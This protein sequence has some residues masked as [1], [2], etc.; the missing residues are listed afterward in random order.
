MLGVNGR[1]MIS[2]VW[3]AL[4][5]IPES[6]VA[7]AGDHNDAVNL[8]LQPI[9][10][11]DNLDFVGV[12]NSGQFLLLIDKTERGLRGD[13][14]TKAPIVS[15]LEAKQNSIVHDELCRLVLLNNTDGPIVRPCRY[16]TL[17]HKI[18]K[19]GRLEPEQEI[20]GA[21]RE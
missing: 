14:R 7:V 10:D 12:R 1:G 16:R 20:R 4:S 3:P 8:R 11:I 15:L 13:V 6:L 18:V 5:Q 17:N 9:E 21:L 2:A 19:R